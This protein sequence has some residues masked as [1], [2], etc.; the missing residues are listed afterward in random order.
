MT[1]CPLCGQPTPHNNHDLYRGLSARAANILLASG[2][3]SAADVRIFVDNGG[4]L[5]NLP[6]VG[7]G[8]EREILEWANKEHIA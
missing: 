5:R 6:G 8:L 7:A 1:K 3:R 4:S 2:L